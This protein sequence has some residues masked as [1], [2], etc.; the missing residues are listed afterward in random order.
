M[1]ENSQVF[2]SVK[3]IFDLAIKHLLTLKKPQEMEERPESEQVENHSRVLLGLLINKRLEGAYAC[4]K[5][6]IQL[7]CLRHILLV[8]NTICSILG[9]NKASTY[10]NEQ[11]RVLFKMSENERR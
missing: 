9:W 6:D 5:A 2:N 1:S 8:L 10:I 4:Y 3:A 7:E 11:N